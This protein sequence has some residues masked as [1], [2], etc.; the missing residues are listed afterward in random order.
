MGNPAH[1]GVQLTACVCLLASVTAQPLAETPAASTSSSLDGAAVLRIMPHSNDVQQSNFGSN[2]FTIT[3]TGQKD[4]AEVVI[5]VT[6]SLYPDA[7]FDPEGLAGDSVAKPL[8]LDTRGQTG[9]LDIGGRGGSAYLGPGGA[10]GYDGL[11]L[12]FDPNAEGGFNPGETVGFSIDMDPNSI[13]GTNKGPLDNGTHPWWD[14]GGVSG[15]ELIG[16]RFTVTFADGSTATGQLH[17]TA[18][19][20]GS[21]A[22]ASQASPNLALYVSANGLG[23]GGVGTYTHERNRVILR[24]PAGHTARV[25]VTHGFI[26]PVT[27]YNDALRRQL[28]TLANASFPANN[29]VGFQTVDVRLTGDNQ[30]IAARLRFTGVPGYDFT[31]RS[32]HPFSIDH[33]KLPVGIVAAIV[34]PDNEHLPIGPVTPPIYLTLEP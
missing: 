29:A 31:A 3:N 30:D 13:A 9:V 12:V 16:S 25:V 26:Q 7:V 32:N 4:I 17:S 33:D 8:N 18:T 6:T 28:D 20:A 24:G 10:T 27:A 34:D 21:H 5:D 2:S 11:R 15:A 23:P 14:V 1:P 22:L 19:Q